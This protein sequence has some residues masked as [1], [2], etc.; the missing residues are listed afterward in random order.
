MNIIG[1]QL[2]CFRRTKTIHT[3]PDTGTTA[4]TGALKFESRR[5]VFSLP[6]ASIKELCKDTGRGGM[7][8]RLS[9]QKFVNTEI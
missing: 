2:E 7:H 1:N 8:G 5:T 4:N 9:N 3:L 6:M